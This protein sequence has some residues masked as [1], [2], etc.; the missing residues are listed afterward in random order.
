MFLPF[1]RLLH[2]VHILCYTVREMNN[3][4]HISDHLLKQFNTVKHKT[5]SVANFQSWNIFFY[6]NRTKENK[7]MTSVKG[8]HPATSILH[9]LLFHIAKRT[10]E[11]V[12][13]L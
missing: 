11:T 9:N 1:Q 4:S 8:M 12:C 13:C 2:N 6:Y 5:V 7:S 10:E 3:V